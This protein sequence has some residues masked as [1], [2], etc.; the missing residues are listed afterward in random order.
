MAGDAD[1]RPVFEGFVA[2]SKRLIVAYRAAKDRL[3]VLAWDVRRAGAAVDLLACPFAGRLRSGSWCSRIGAL[4]DVELKAIAKA[5]EG[6][7]A[8]SDG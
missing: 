1:I 8:S 2:G 6:H 5:L 3:D 4:P 7:G